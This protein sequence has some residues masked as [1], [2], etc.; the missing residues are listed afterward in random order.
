MSDEQKKKSYSVRE[1]Y[2]SYEVFYVGN[3]PGSL[4]NEKSQTNAVKYC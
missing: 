1:E 2:D 4:I 3:H